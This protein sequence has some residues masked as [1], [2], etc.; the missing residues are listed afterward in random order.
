VAPWCA[1]HQAKLKRV[2]YTV[3]LLLPAQADKSNTVIDTLRR[4]VMPNIQGHRAFP[5]VDQK[6]NDGMMSLCQTETMMWCDEPSGNIANEIL[7]KSPTSPFGRGEHFGN[8]GHILGA[9][10]D[11]A[12]RGDFSF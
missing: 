11:G 10:S 5:T 2:L 1:S 7:C 9:T 3:Y 4:V 6:A 8:C 12:Y